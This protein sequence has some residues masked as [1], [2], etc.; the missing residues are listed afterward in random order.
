[1]GSSSTRRQ[2]CATPEGPYVFEINASTKPYPSW[3]SDIEDGKILRRRR[4]T[5]DTILDRNVCFVDTASPEIFS[6]ISQYMRMHLRKAMKAPSTANREF[7][8][9]LSG[10]GGSQV[11]VIFYMLSKGEDSSKGDFSAFL[12]GTDTLDLDISQMKALSELGNV[13]PLI[14]K[15]D[16]LSPEDI[17]TLKVETRSRFDATMLPRMPVFGASDPQSR[18]EDASAPYTVSSAAGPDHETMD[19]SLLMSPDY[20][21]PLIPSE[22]AVLVQEIFESETISYLRHFAA[23]KL[24]AWQAAHPQPSKITTPAQQNHFFSPR[25]SG[26]TSPVPCAVSN[27]GVLVSFA[28]DQSLDPASNKLAMVRLAEHALEEERLAQVRLGKWANDLQNSLQRERERF[29]KLARG[30][31]ATWLVERMSEEARDG[32]LSVLDKSGIPVKASNGD[33]ECSS[34]ASAKYSIHDPLGLLSWSDNVKSRSWI[35]FQVLGSFGMIG[36]LA[37]WFAKTWGLTS[38]VNEWAQGWSWNGFGLGWNN[39]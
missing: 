27:S 7:A 30:E 31:R 29:E 14:S 39:T 22:L 19:A 9:L 2:V 5:G 17:E 8:A 26:L 32:R 11:D 4:S 18:A 23:K 20:V 33:E 36:G 15:S 35:A 21:Q 13:V 38:A 34:W 25:P 3:W 12:T 37:F 24:I 28:S 16:L 6:T 1:V 10:S